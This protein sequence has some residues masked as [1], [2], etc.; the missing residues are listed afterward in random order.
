MPYSMLSK[1]SRTLKNLRSDR[2]DIAYNLKQTPKQF[3][4]AVKLVT[5]YC[6]TSYRQPAD[7]LM[8]NLRGTVQGNLYDELSQ[9]EKHKR[10]ITFIAKPTKKRY[11]IT[12]QNLYL[13]EGAICSIRR[14]H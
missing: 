6:Y 4:N 13:W 7:E 11:N 10:Q 3:L 12:S 14:E 9:I 1:S 2:L 5:H 8:D